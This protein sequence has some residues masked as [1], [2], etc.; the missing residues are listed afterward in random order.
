MGIEN[1]T[2]G[3]ARVAVINNGNR[4]N[5]ASTLLVSYA[6]S[7]KEV[8]GNLGY[9]KELVLGGVPL[10]VSLFFY[11][12][13]PSLQDIA[14]TFYAL[15]VIENNDEEDDVFSPSAE[16]NVP[17][18]P[19]D[20]TFTLKGNR[21]SAS[22][23]GDRYYMNVVKTGTPG[24]LINVS[25]EVIFMGIPMRQ[26]SEAELVVRKIGTVFSDVEELVTFMVGG[27]PLTAGRIGN[28]YYLIVS[29]IRAK[30]A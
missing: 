23:K 14:N 29:P 18:D 27:S 28:N 7:S 12:T 10:S 9:K 8:P 1:V 30:D 2:I 17:T 22:K 16:G 3:G 26:G 11:D 13:D 20:K 15:N 19:S 4:D 25:N 6:D 21:L 5:F 24:S